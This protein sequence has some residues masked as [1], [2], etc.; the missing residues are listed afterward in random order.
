MMMP[1]VSF[2]CSFTDATIPNSFIDIA[3]LEEPRATMT[4][5]ASSKSPRKKQS[6]LDTFLTTNTVLRPDLNVEPPHITGQHPSSDEFDPDVEVYGIMT[7]DLMA[8]T[9]IL[10]PRNFPQ[11]NESPIQDEEIFAT[12]P[13][14]PPPPTVNPETYV[15][16]QTDL[17]RLPPLSPSSKKRAH[18][19][20]MKPPM[21][22]KNTRGRFESLRCKYYSVNHLEPVEAP[23][24]ETIPTAVPDESRTTPIELLPSKS[25]DSTTTFGTLATTTPSA[26][27][28]PNTSFHSNS[29]TSSINSSAET[30][31]RPDDFMHDMP[32]QPTRPEVGN[33]E[34]ERFLK[35]VDDVG[36]SESMDI[37][38]PDPRFLGR[39]D[40]TSLSHPKEY[41]ANAVDHGK[42]SDR[43]ENEYSPQQ[44]F[45]SNL[46]CEPGSIH[47]YNMLSTP[48]I[49]FSSTKFSKE[50]CCV[51]SS[52]VR[53]NPSLTGY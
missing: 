25:F 46:L 11:G 31:D 32:S 14:T 17:V 3:K 43:K 21:A 53:S 13:S 48:L 36:E 2:F 9:P 24:S 42:I 33:V 20:S 41:S 50:I 16:K 45:S 37:D 40:L 23:D 30:T 5:N 26:S 51:I 52:V 7:D 22:R 34:V 12:P 19:E 1:A 29:M 28:T 4:T 39:A 10:E 8:E 35:A 38:G 49:S 44:F 18:E 6:R 15:L 47:D 27:W